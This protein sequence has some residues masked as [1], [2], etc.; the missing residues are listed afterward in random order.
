MVTTSDRIE[1]EADASFHCCNCHL[2]VRAIVTCFGGTQVG[3]E[4]RP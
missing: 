1:G 4:R 3:L 2:G